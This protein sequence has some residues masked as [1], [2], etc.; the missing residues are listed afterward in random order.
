MSSKR[1]RWCTATNKLNAYCKQWEHRGHLMKMI[2]SW[3]SLLQL[4]VCVCKNWNT[5]GFKNKNGKLLFRGWRKQQVLKQNWNQTETSASSTELFLVSSLPAWAHV[6]FHNFL[7]LCESLEPHF[8]IKTRAWL[9]DF[10][11]PTAVCYMCRMSTCLLCMTVS[12]R[13]NVQRLFLQLDAEDGHS[14]RIRWAD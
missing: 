9:P 14:E 4:R 5:A 6:S 13:T 12:V 1:W 2:S 3:P 7:R 8:W 11:S 10:G